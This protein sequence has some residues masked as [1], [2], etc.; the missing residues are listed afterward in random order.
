MGAGCCAK[1][2]PRHILMAVGVFFLALVCLS[3]PMAWAQ[4]GDK[5]GSE[6]AV[7]K[8]PKR[9]IIRFLT[10]NDFPPFNYQDED[11]V[12]TGFN[13][14]LARAIC[15][16]LDVTCNIELRP[17]DKLLPNLASGEAD[18]VIASI[19]V[20]PQTLKQADFSNRYYF[21]PGRFI[22]RQEFEDYEMTPVGLE[23]RTLAV[24]RGSAHEAFINK[25]FRD[26]KVVVFD[27]GDL[28]RQAL[29]N[30]KVELMFGDG[31]GL[32]FW[33]NGTQSAACCELRGG[34]YSDQTYFGDGIGIA[35]RKGDN[36]LR[37]QI[38]QALDVIRRAGR[39]EELFLRY[40]PMKV[41]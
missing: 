19:K 25:Y 21:T 11:G 13:V 20:T 22:A 10:A 17:W 6:A 5:E 1:M 27:N 23:G 7:Q 12:L 31:M 8:A 40:F 28:A 2:T 24:V 30:G 29:K 39:I 14:D 36:L 38:N 18:A 35:V 3:M 16:E 4:I 9:S 33:V 32:M 34:A 41:Y 37:K 26:C 15:L